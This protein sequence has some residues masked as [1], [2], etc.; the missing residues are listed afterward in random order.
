MDKPITVKV[1]W[2]GRISLTTDGL[3]H[4]KIKEGDSL[5]MSPLPNEMVC[6]KKLKADEVGIPG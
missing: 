5:I 6:L 3:E 4:L 2:G 1:T